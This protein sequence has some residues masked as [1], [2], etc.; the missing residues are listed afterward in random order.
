MQQGCAERHLVT[1]PAPEPLHQAG[2]DGREAIEGPCHLT[3]NGTCRV[4]I[5]KEVHTPSQSLHE[6]LGVVEAMHGHGQAIQAVSAHV[7]WAHGVAVVSGAS[8]FQGLRQERPRGIAPVPAALSA[9]QRLLGA[10]EPRQFPVDGLRPGPRCVLLNN[11]IQKLGAASVGTS[12]DR[13][14]QEKPQE[15]ARGCCHRAR[16]R[17]ARGLLA[18]LSSLVRTRAEKYGDRSQTHDRAVAGILATG[19]KAWGGAAILHV[20]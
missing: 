11:L 12:V 17:G 18:I 4:G 14:C 1:V 20:L 2:V 7:V 5:P 6:G 8:R 19:L 9:A 15:V 13:P 16:V 10:Q 3:A